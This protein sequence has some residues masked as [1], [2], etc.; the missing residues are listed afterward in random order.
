MKTIK[1]KHLCKDP[2]CTFS[3]GDTEIIW[4]YNEKDIKGKE[5]ICP[6]CHKLLFDKKGL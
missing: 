6:Y 5:S 1:I 2:N 4:E 3:M